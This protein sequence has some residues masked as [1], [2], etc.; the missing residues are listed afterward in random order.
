MTARFLSPADA[1]AAPA[2]GPQEVRT[3]Q[4]GQQWP[5]VVLAYAYSGAGRI[6][7]LL[8]GSD[9]LACTSGTGLLPLCAQAAA[10]WQRVENRDE[11]LS[12][13]ARSSLRAL[14][15]SMITVILAGT[16]RSRWC[17]I[18]FSPPAAAETFLELYPETKFVCLH[19]SC[20][21]VIRA[22][23]EANPWGLAGTG[24]G[25]FT[26]A[27]PGNSAAAIAAYWAECTESMLRFQEEHP[28][29][30]RQV[31]YED[32]TG[33]PDQE[34][35]DIFAFLGL[36]AAASLPADEATSAPPPGAQIPAGFL[37]L[38]LTER[39]NDLQGRLGYPPIA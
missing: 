12:T 32:L 5:V 18:S 15:G 30:C 9:L 23:I 20:P 8:S 16:G 11:P 24:P 37:P 7:R 25:Q 29:A 6:Q 21:E 2:R 17:E 28:A 19:R 22:C 38:P 10:T 34:A 1:R 27:Y 39:V 13:L 26:L 14:A 3:A 31:R 33:N 36:A 4:P 35:G